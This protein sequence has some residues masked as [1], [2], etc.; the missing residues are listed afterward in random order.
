MN[1]KKLIISFLAAFGITFASFAPAFAD[2]VSVNFE[3]P[4]YSV[5]SI[6]GQNGWSNAVNPT[7][8]QGVVANTFGYSSFGGQ[9]LRMSDAV[10]SG[11]F[12]D[13][14]FAKPLTDS[15][16]E[17]S[18]SAGTFSVGNKKTHFETQFDIASTVPGAQQP[19]LH[20]SVSPDRGDGSRMSYLRFE[21][22]ATGI[23]VFFDDVQGTTSPANFVETKVASGLDRTVTHRV[24]LTMDTLDGPS[25]DVVK[26]YVDGNLVHTGTSWENYYRFDSEASTEQSTR[27]VKTVIFQARGTATPGDIGKGFLFDNFSMS[28]GSVLVTPPSSLDQCKNSGWKDFNNPSF[29][30]QGQCVAYV[31]THN[32]VV[33]GFVK[34][35]AYGLNRT[36]DLAMTTA[37]NSGTFFYS[38]ANHDSYSVKV[39]E[40]RV[41]GNDAYFAGKV[42]HASN[43]S[44]VG[45]WLF[46]K[47]EDNNPDKIWGSFTSQTAAVNGVDIMSDPTDGPFSVTSGSISVH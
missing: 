18:A 23:D 2:T 12:G 29:T 40:V 4:Q 21:D 38:D 33:I 42:T 13:W 22:G 44:W 20:V 10:T 37:L 27:I 14:V 36:A 19:G 11:S 34:Y 41:N 39:S 46:A 26:V 16:G 6:S 17:S 35:N 1:T 9:S 8:D 3:N 30:N 47:V 45:Q 7:Y 32:H 28:S 31:A 25:N 24:K 5:G 43:P 15:V